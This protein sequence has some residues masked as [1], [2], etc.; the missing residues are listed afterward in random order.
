MLIKFC[1]LI[2]KSLGR[3]K[4]R[5]FLTGLGITVLVCVGLAVFEA[6]EPTITVS[7]GASYTE[8]VAVWLSSGVEKKKVAIHRIH[9]SSGGAK[10][11]NVSFAGPAAANVYGA[12]AA[13]EVSGL[14][15]LSPDKT[16]S[17][18]GA[19]LTPATSA[20]SSMPTC[21]APPR[22]AVPYVIASGRARASSRCRTSTGS[23]H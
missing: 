19:S 12:M 18:S 13:H 22:P 1:I 17:G 7:D 3:N 11:I 20:N 23:T 21:V 6:T 14:D 5:T 16:M 4:V 10:T 8:D 15:N 9:N 2:I